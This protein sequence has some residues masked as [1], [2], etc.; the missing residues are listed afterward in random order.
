M[1]LTFGLGAILGPIAQLI[2]DK[3]L[4]G[5]ADAIAGYEK[6]LSDIV[7]NTAYDNQDDLRRADLKR[8]IDIETQAYMAQVKLLTK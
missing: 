6:E 7:N 2:A 3:V 5:H 4:M 8:L 1:D